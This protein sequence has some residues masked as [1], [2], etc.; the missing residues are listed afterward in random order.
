M[1]S[2]ENGEVIT[3]QSCFYCGIASQDLL[4]CGDCEFVSACSAKHLRIHK[5]AETLNKTGY[6]TGFR[7][8]SCFAFTVRHCPDFGRYLVANRDIGSGESVFVDFPFAFGPLSKS[9]ATCL[10]CFKLV[11]LMSGPTEEQPDLDRCP[12]CRL[13]LCESCKFV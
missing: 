3:N 2:F 13:P 10:G 4:R 12:E 5:P 7:P 9:V 1:T 11:K 6:K 8:D